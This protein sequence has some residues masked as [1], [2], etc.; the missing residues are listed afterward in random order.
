[1]IF[2]PRKILKRSRLRFFRKRFDDL[3]VSNEEENVNAQIYIFQTAII[4]PSLSNQSLVFHVSE[5]NQR[6]SQNFHQP[7]VG[8]EDNDS[9]Q[10]SSRLKEYATQH[11]FAER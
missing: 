8:P 1:M 9:N 11:N 2:L 10:W 3:N 4:S 5:P 6:R 7:K